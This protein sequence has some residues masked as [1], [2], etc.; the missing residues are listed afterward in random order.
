M[1][2][3][4]GR[5]WWVGWGRREKEEEEGSQLPLVVSGIWG[6]SVE[7]SIQQLVIGIWAQG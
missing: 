3:D 6:H 2:G 7:V 1:T 5:Q 4:S